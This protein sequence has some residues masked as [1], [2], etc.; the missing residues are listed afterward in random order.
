MSKYF[1]W[2]KA[3]HICEKHKGLRIL[4]GMNEDWFWTADEIFDGEKRVNGRPWLS[5]DWATPVCRVLNE[6]GSTLVIP[7]F[8]TDEKIEMPKWWVERDEK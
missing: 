2:N 1:D 3:K 8:Q 6:D 4:A 5:S 7:C